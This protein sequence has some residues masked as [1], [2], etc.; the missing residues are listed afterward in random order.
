MWIAFTPRSR[1]SRAQPRRSAGSSCGS[2][3][4][5]APISAASL[6]S[7]ETRPGFAPCLLTA[8]GARPTSPRGPVMPSARA[9]QRRL[10]GELGDQA[11]VGALRAHG[12][13]AATELAAQ[14]D[15]AL[16][17]RVVRA[18]GRR[19]GGVEVDAAPRLH[20]RVEVERAPLVAEARDGG[21]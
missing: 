1:N 18:F 10:L 12:G 19:E 13:R 3:V 5:R 15:H 21:A 6:A 11:G 20:H 2:P 14:L 8:V 4:S 9:D 7:W 17:Q 16:A